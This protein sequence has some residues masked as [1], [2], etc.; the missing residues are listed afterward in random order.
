MIRPLTS[1]IENQ[2]VSTSIAQW[3][4]TRGEITQTNET[5]N[6][7]T[8]FE[9]DTTTSSSEYSGKRIKG[10]QNLLMILLVFLIL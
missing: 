8:L 1:T 6:N 2:A 9:A 4:T 7:V 10:P 3:R 5:Q